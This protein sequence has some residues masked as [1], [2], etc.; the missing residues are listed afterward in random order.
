MTNREM[1]PVPHPLSLSPS[2]LSIIPYLISCIPYHKS[3][4]HNPLYLILYPLSLIF[5][6]LYYIPYSLIYEGWASEA[7]PSEINEGV[8]FDPIML[9]SICY[10]VYLGATGKKLARNPKF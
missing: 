4:I 3:L 5:N 7:H 10:L 6:P 2:S 8:I 9:Y 1:G